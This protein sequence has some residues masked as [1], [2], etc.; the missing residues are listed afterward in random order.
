VSSLGGKPAGGGP[1][2]AR[3][4]TSLIDAAAQA[5][6]LGVSADLAGKR[7]DRQGTGCIK[8][9]SLLCLDDANDFDPG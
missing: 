9:S 1:T 3:G 5:A 8:A 4:V 6:I 7:S 2:N